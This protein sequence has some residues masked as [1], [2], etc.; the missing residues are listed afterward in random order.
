M[1]AEIINSHLLI[2]EWLNG[3]LFPITLNLALIIGVYL[4]RE[5]SGS[6]KNRTMFF[7]IPGVQ[8]AFVL[9][10]LFSAETARAG[11]MWFRLRSENNGYPIDASVSSFLDG[12]LIVC[13]T[14]LV[15]TV[16]RCTYLFTPP[17]IRGFFWAYSLLLM[18]AFTLVSNAIKF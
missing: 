10:W 16:L 9:F 8:T 2:R 15:I 14:V 4:C 12:T 11:S 5:W 7:Q 6:R 13:G 1:Y 18:V 17:R 3:S